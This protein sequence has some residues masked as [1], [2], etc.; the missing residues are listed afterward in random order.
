MSH[1]CVLVLSPNKVDLRLAETFI[2][3]QLAPYDENIK[4]PEYDRKCSCSEYRVRKEATDYANSK[5]DINTLRVE[6]EQKVK[7]LGV[8]ELLW[9]EFTSEWFNIRENFE[10]QH[11]LYGKSNPE[12]VECKG[13]GIYKSTYNPNSKWDWYQIGGRYTG[14]ISNRKAVN[15]DIVSL[16]SIKK[17]GDDKIPYALVTPDK[18]WHQKGTMGWWGISTNEDKN[19]KEVA[20]TLLEKYKDCYAIVV[21]CHI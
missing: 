10:K 8:G 17:F 3:T 20:R 4:V 16:S 18:A 5:I 2:K 7:Q 9:S 21:D 11:P 13:T 12:C 6:F 15:S 19:W 1:F 14:L